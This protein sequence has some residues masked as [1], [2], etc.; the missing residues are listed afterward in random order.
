MITIK[1]KVEIKDMVDKE[2][3]SYKKNN[4]LRREIIS[5]IKFKVNEKDEK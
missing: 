1:D 5:S 2:K 4:E 3:N